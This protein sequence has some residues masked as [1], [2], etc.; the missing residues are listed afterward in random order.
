[1]VGPRSALLALLLVGV[2]L[3]PR[4]TSAQS[5][6]L[7]TRAPSRVPSPTPADSTGA[8][9][10]S[11]AMLRSALLPGW[12]QLY[13]GHPFKAAWVAAAGA[14]FVTLTVRADARV[15]ELAARRSATPDPAT[16]S[17]LEADIEAWR[18]ERRRWLVWSVTLWIYAVVDAYVDA[19][20]YDFDAE[21]PR[22]RLSLGAPG[23][24]SRAPSLLLQVSLG[25]SR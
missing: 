7:E 16:R 22:F 20:L 17:A 14:T 10:P 19:E 21:E 13:T 4:L 25:R 24:W 6:A 12:G 18:I 2:L 15:G 9:R 1:M 5:S 11:A 3:A 23:P 8:P